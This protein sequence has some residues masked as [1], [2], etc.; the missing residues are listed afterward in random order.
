MVLQESSLRGG[1]GGR[2]DGRE[3]VRGLRT[4]R[5]PLPSEVGTVDE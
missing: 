5:G 2:L 4:P 1:H 3:D